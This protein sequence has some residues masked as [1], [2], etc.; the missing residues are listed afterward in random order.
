MRTI[1]AVLMRIA[2]LV[3][4][5]CFGVVRGTALP[6]FVE[7]S[8]ELWPHWLRLVAESPL[9]A[10]VQSIRILPGIAPAGDRAELVYGGEG[11]IVGY[12]PLVP[13]V[14]LWDER[15]MATRNEVAEGA[16]RL[17]PLTAVSLPDIALPLDGLLPDEPGYPLYRKVTLRLESR[18]RRLRTWLG[19]LEEPPGLS[20]SAKTQLAWIEAVGDVMPARGVD[21]MLLSEGGVERVFGD[22]LPLL[23]GCQLLLGNLESSTAS[24]GTAENKSYTFR[25]RAAAVGKLKDAGFS[26]LSLANNHT[27]DFGK[28]GFLDTL[29]SLSWCGIR[30]S[31]AGKDIQA[32]SRPIVAKA[33][34]QE[35]RILSFGAFPVDKTGFDGRVSER[36]GSSRPGI[37]WLDDDGLASASQAFTPDAFNIAFI[38]GG[39]EWSRTVTPEQKRLYR[40]LLQRGADLVLGAHPHV[41]Q[42]MEAVDGKLIAYSLG[43]FLFPGMQSTPGGQDSV[44]LRLGIYDGKIRYVQCLPVRLSG[45]IVRRASTEEARKELLAETRAM[46]AEPASSIEGWQKVTREVLQ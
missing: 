37:L 33:G 44:I 28:E 5:L 9:P 30:T 11:K 23:H 34:T 26:Y 46:N 32:A 38:H 13:V 20:G 45:G 29:A 42:G 3:A 41:L 14:K 1:T 22:T 36:A 2:L 27:Y 17:L 31:G 21:E 7:V 25:F 15:K 16:V 12:V 6:L 10:G 35:V 19:S 4:T 18:D 24:H 43:N 39:T 8:D 40:E